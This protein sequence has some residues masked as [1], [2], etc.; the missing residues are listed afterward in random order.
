MTALKNPTLTWDGKTEYL[1]FPT[2]DGSSIKT[3]AIEEPTDWQYIRDPQELQFN[4]IPQSLHDD[5]G[6]KISYGYGRFRAGYEQL[7]NVPAKQRLLVKVTYDLQ[8]GSPNIVYGQIL[9]SGVPGAKS[10]RTLLSGGQEK[11]FVFST[12][13]AGEVNIAFVVSADFAVAPTDVYIHSISL[14]AVPADYGGAIVPTVMPFADEITP[15]PVP[16]P[17]PTPL[18]IPVPVPTAPGAQ[19]TFSFQG[20]VAE[21][22]QFIEAM[23][24]L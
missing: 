13:Q 9:V 24:G 5:D 2:D 18:P 15:A 3:V 16:T 7:V 8:S 19:I 1:N 20:T 22:V 21:F 6:M 14:E 10:D 17:T 23:R 12:G 11:L 4:N